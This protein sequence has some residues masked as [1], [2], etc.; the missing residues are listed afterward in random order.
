TLFIALMVLV[1]A[2]VATTI[3]VGCTKYE[4]TEA[5]ALEMT[6]QEIEEYA[7]AVKKGNTTLLNQL[8]EFFALNSTSELIEKSLKF[9][10][11]VTTEAP[12]DASILNDNTGD[13]IT[14]VTEAGFAPYEYEGAGKGAVNKVIGIDVDLMIAF[15]EANNYKLKLINTE[16]KTIIA[17]VDKSDKAIGAAGMTVN[18]ERLEKV[19]FATPY[20]ETIQY[21]ISDK[22]NSFTTTEQLAG[23]KVGVQNSTTG[24][25]YVVDAF[26]KAIDDGEISAEKINKKGYDKVMAAY[27]DL[28]KGKI[29]A[30]VIDEYVAKGLVENDK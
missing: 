14:M 10:T 16:F 7:F 1:T 3:L 4:F 26:N 12:M 27:N 30:I 9:H 22:A 8:N 25:Y 17:E 21:I 5:V 13:E 24:E 6:D 18:E 20:I 28:K 15:A 2:A 19:D 29:A 11:G 23:L